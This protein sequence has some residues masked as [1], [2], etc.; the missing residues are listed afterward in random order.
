VQQSH[1]GK[2]MVGL[3]MWPINKDKLNLNLNPAH[4]WGNTSG[5][6]LIIQGLL[7]EVALRIQTNVREG[8]SNWNH[9]FLTKYEF[10]MNFQSGLLK[11]ISKSA[12]NQQ[13]VHSW[14]SSYSRK[15][16]TILYF[17][18]MAKTSMV[19]KKSLIHVEL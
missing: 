15:G 11:G 5:E 18:K 19:L 17:P 8:D 13:N 7:I 2:H 4:Q 10:V 1:Q 16:I 3:N 12:Q 9:I 6:N 14:W